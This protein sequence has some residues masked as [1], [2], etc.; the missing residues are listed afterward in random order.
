MRIIVFLLLFALTFSMDGYAQKKSSSGGKARTAKTV[1]T[2]NAKKTSKSSSTK[3][4]SAK[5]VSKKTPVKKETSAD[6]KRREQEARQEIARTKKQIQENEAQVKKN[7]NEL[8]RIQSDIEVGEKI[9]GKTTAEVTSL[10]AKITTLENEI[11]TNEAQLA[12][13]RADYLQ[14]LKKIRAR[15]KS[16]SD[17]AFIF[18]AESFKQALQRMRY[19]RQ[20]SEWRQKKTKEITRTVETLSRDKEELAKNRE[21]KDQTLQQQLQAQHTLQTK[22]AKQDAVVADLRKNG[23]ALQSHLSK[24]QAEANALKGRI[25][26][27]I[28]EE[29]RKAEA[30][31]KAEEARKAKA[32]EAKRVAEQKKAD[33]SKRMEEAKKA[34]ETQKTPEGKPKKQVAQSGGETNSAKKDFAEARN[35]KPRTES[36]PKKESA[37]DSGSTVSKGAKPATGSGFAS[38]KGSLPRPVTG[39]FRVTSKFGKHALPDL[40]DVVYD[41]PGIDAETTS[42]AK[43]QAVYGGKVSGVYMIPG[44][45]T[46]VIVNHGDYYTVYGNI[47]S[48]SVKVGDQVKP[49]D[50]LGSLAADEDNPGHSSIHFEVWHNRD[51]LNPEAWIR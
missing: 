29:N 35:K 27:L 10:D 26:S 9:V 3:K 13:M 32:E 42:G 4:T 25:A 18:G 19:L 50:S 41:N 47:S 45:N 39:S 33:E 48:V 1:Q 24:K 44:F 5:V 31:R 17:L 16:G 11:S 23:K 34:S 40:P 8:G 15:K 43:A 46:V 28:A 20:I 12:K 37:K 7:L 2:T 49:G 21:L 22:Y 51:K 14:S 36:Q 30:A 6:V 38:M